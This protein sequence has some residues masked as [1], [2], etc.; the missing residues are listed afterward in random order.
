LGADKVA[1][2]ISCKI[3]D[4]SPLVATGDGAYGSGLLNNLCHRISDI[5]AENLIPIVNS[6]ACTYIKQPGR[7]EISID[8][9]SMGQI[10]DCMV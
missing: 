8:D 9:N 5:I 1:K 3:I 2:I 4:S 10:L 6:D 7:G